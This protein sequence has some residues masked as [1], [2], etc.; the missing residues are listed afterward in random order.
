MLKNKDSMLFFLCYLQTTGKQQV[1][2]DAQVQ[3]G[4]LP[5]ITKIKWSSRNNYPTFMMNTC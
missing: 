2:L 4:K 1:Q 3:Y 5:A